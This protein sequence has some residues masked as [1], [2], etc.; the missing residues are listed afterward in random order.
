[1][2]SSRQAAIGIVITGNIA[3]LLLSFGLAVLL[4]EIGESGINTRPWQA[5]VGLAVPVL[6]LLGAA[7]RIY[8]RGRSP[9][10][11][12]RLGIATAGGLL[13]GFTGIAIFAS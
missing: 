6:L 7:F 12:R 13:L 9:R 1:M 8:S 2:D 5:I 11:L 4:F 3:G 10:L